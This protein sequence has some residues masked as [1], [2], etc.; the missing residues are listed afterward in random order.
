GD[1]D[2]VHVEVALQHNDGYSESVRAFANNIYNVEGG[3]HLSGFRSALTRTIN[4]YGKK[5]GIFKDTIPAGEDFRDG[6][7]AIVSVRVP[8]PHFEAQTKARLTNIEVEGIVTSV[9]N[10]GLA[11]HL[12]ENPDVAK[13]IAQKGLRALEAREAARKA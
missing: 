9:V 13:L 5:E 10:E 2:A 4:A 1:Q 7:T 3:T 12:E 8:D 6:L 11:R